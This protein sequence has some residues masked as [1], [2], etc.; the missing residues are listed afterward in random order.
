VDAW[1]RG[2]RVGKE[3]EVKVWRQIASDFPRGWQPHWVAQTKSFPWT[4]LK[5]GFTLSPTS[6]VAEVGW[7]GEKNTSLLLARA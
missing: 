6:M 5:D 2:V 4:T 3:V 7:R 1:L